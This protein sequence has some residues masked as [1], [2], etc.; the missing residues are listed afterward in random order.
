MFPIVDASILM[1]TGT[2]HKQH[3][4]AKILSGVGKDDTIII[5]ISLD[6]PIKVQCLQTE[7]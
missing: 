2:G 7:N 6:S 5:E 3:V 4:M 1:V